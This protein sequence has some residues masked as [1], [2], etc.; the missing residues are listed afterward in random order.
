MRRDPPLSP[1]RDRTW[2]S[3]GLGQLLPT[4]SKAYWN[5]TPRSRC[6]PGVAFSSPQPQWAGAETQ[7]TGSIQGQKPR[8]FPCQ[9]P[10]NSLRDSRPGFPAYAVPFWAC[11]LRGTPGH[12]DRRAVSSPPRSAQYSQRLHKQGLGLP[13][14]L[15]SEMTQR[16]SLSPGLCSLGLCSLCFHLEGPS[17]TLRTSPRSHEAQHSYYRAPCP[18]RDRLWSTVFPAML[19]TLGSGLGILSVVSPQFTAQRRCSRTCSFLTGGEYNRGP[20]TPLL[21][22]TQ[23]PGHPAPS[24]QVSL[25]RTDLFTVPRTVRLLVL[26][27]TMCLQ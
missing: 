8:A 5:R 24:W 25:P 27:V 15:L 9:R 16:T 11:E 1:K 2:F 26:A 21:L 17:F 7:T 10:E 22:H 13:T 20:G 14:H 4:D 12:D 19:R 6:T 18:H 3:S 23:A